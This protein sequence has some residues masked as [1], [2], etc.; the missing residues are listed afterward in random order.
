MANSED[1]DYK[2]I[3]LRGP[4]KWTLTLI[5]IAGCWAPR[6]VDKTTALRYKLYSL[7]IIGNTIAI[8]VCTEIAYI[9]FNFGK[10][11]ELAR[12]MVLFLTHLSQLP[13][14]ASLIVHRQKIYGLLDAM[15]EDI[16]K[17]RNYRQ[18]REAT[19]IVSNSNK[20]AKVFMAVVLTTALSIGVFPLLES[21]SNGELPFRAWYPFVVSQSPRFDVMCVY[22]MVTVLFWG[23]TNA[24]MDITAA[25]F[26]I[27]VCIQFNILSD[28]VLHV[29]EFAEAKEDIVADRDGLSEELQNE[30]ERLLLQNVKHHLKIKRCLKQIP[31]LTIK[32]RFR[33][34]RFVTDMLTA[35]SVPIFVHFAIAAG[36]ICMTMFEMTLVRFN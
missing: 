32:H 24:A 6:N 13:K 26:M 21:D 5:R 33:I 20:L 11:E 28:S 30:M 35:F 4:L 12:S 34:S 8:F 29:R 2:D 27:Q 16:F 15:D 23:C 3:D 17:P 25:M 18:S 1:G 7:L 19:N 22:Q 36:S 14:I 10:L 9:I 31:P